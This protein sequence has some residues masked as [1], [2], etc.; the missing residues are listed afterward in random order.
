[1]VLCPFDSN[2]RMPEKSLS[3]HLEKCELRAN[4]FQNQQ[5]VCLVIHVFQNYF[6]IFNN[7]FSKS[8]VFKSKLFFNCISN[9]I[10]KSLIQSNTYFT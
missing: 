9:F 10:D 3:K 1:M 5:I 7:Y 4:G 8:I 6:L 2:H